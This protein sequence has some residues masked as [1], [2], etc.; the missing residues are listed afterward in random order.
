MFINNNRWHDNIPIH[1]NVY[2]IQYA[3][4]NKQLL[5][6]RITKKWCTSGLQLHTKQTKCLK[7][8]SKKFFLLLFLLIISNK[9]CKDPEKWSYRKDLL[10]SYVRGYFGLMAAY[11]N[12][13]I[14]HTQL[15][16]EGRSHMWE[17]SGWY[18]VFTYSKELRFLKWVYNSNSTG[19][20]HGHDLQNHLPTGHFFNYLIPTQKLFTSRAVKQLCRCPST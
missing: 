19:I 17:G 5:L 13:Q 8:Y 20:T 18:T 14:S 9:L 1:V 16:W 2:R 11:A 10:A 15:P 12:H 7:S 4:N 6:P 3:R